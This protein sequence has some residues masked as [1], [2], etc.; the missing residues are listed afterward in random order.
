MSHHPSTPSRREVLKRALA[1]PVTA[2][3]AAATARTAEAMPA[4]GAAARFSSNPV[5]AENERA[6][7]GDWQL[8]RVAIDQL[9]GKRSPRI[10][11]Y[12]SRQSVE[13]GENLEFKVSADPGVKFKIEI[14]RLGYYGGKGARKIAGPRPARSTHAAAPPVTETCANELAT[15]E[16]TI[17]RDWPGRLYRAHDH[18]P[19]APGSGYWQSYVIFIV[20]DERPAD[21][22]FQCSDNTWQAYNR[23]PDDFSLYTHPQGGQRAVGGREL[24][25]SLRPKYRR[26]FRQPAVD[27]LGRV[28]AAWSFRSPTGWSS[29]ATT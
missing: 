16:I 28:P 7:S 9:G 3:A 23:W 13:A 1:A 18:D 4:P 12:C 22:L 27:R 19:R 8:T 24:R 2:A 21:I 20:R 17:P 6:G 14:F 25:S 26:D 29:T 15:R 10:E 11:G 5:L